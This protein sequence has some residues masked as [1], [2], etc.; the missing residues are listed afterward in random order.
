MSLKHFCDEASMAFLGPW[1]G[2]KQRDFSFEIFRFH[3]PQHFPLL[4]QFEKRLFI[5][6]P[7]T[8]LAISVA[9][10]RARCEERLVLVADAQ[11]AIEEERKIGI[12]REPRQLADAVLPNVYDLS[13]SGLLKKA[14]KFLCRLLGEPDREECRS[15][16]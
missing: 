10:F 6:R 8:R 1:L 2:A 12:L 9:D 7:V 11:N 14:E 16:R 4:H 13:N 5:L 15:H 3:L